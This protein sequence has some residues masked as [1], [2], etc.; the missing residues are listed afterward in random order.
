MVGDEEA[1]GGHVQ[2]AAGQ[3]MERAQK[4]YTATG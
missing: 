1:A 2:G 4:I 3:T